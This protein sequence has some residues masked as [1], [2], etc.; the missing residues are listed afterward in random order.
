M[1]LI[2]IWTYIKVVHTNDVILKF[3]ITTTDDILPILPFITD[4]EENIKNV[5]RLSY[6]NGA[7]FVF[8]MGGVTLREN[9]RDYFFE[10]LDKSFLG[11]KEEYIKTFGN[12]IHAYKKNNQ[13]E[14]LSFI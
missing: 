14:Q 13:Q 8:S 7:K 10:Q 11:L 6:E 9:Q 2:I 12:I 5:V 3:T 4:S 1:E